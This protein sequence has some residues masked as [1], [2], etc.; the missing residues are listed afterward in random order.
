MSVLV[1][2]SLAYDTVMVFDGRF[3]DHILPDRIHSLSVA[4]LVPELRR[5]FGGCAGNIGYNARLLGLDV[6]LLAAAGDDFSDYA[7][8]LADLERRIHGARQ[9]A[10][11]AANDEQIR[12]YHH[13]GRDILERQGR[14]GWGAKVIERLSAD[15]RAEFPEPGSGRCLRCWEWPGYWAG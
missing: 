11:L 4:F 6:A 15:L 14:Q 9:R 3:R 5:N 10:L 8:W 12:L 2:G 13:I 7:A 1:C